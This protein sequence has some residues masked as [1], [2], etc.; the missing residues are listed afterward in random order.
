MS[1][2]T[3]AST[4][5][6]NARRITRASNSAAYFAKQSADFIEANK[7]TISK[8]VKQLYHTSNPTN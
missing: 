5:L 2:Q 6:S 3:H 4:I 8:N 1:V 7:N